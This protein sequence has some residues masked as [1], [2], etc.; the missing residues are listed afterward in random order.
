M[1]KSYSIAIVSILLVLLIGT[2][3]YIRSNPKQ[4]EE[5]ASSEPQIEIAK[6]DS[7]TVSQI[8]IESNENKLNIV[9]E[10]ES[11]ILNGN[12]D[13]TASQSTIDGIANTMS[14]IEAGSV[15]QDIES[16]SDYGLDNP[17]KLK[18][19]LND[20]KVYE[21]F[22]GNSTP[23]SGG[24]YF[25]MSE[26]EK[27]YIVSNRYKTPFEY[28]FEDLV[29]KEEIPSI[30]LENLNYIYI[31][32]VGNLEMEFVKPDEDKIDKYR[33]W[34]NI[35]T[36]EM[37]KPYKLVHAVGS[38]DIWSSVTSS[39]S[40]NSAVR[41]FVSNNP[42]DLSLYGLNKPKLEILVRDKDGVENH[43]YFG[44]QSGDGNVY[45][46]QANS[47]DVYTM[48]KSV[49]DVFMNLKPFDVVDKFNML[50]NIEDIQKIVINSDNKITQFDVTITKEK[51]EEDSERENTK[52]SCSVDGKE[53][54]E[55]D[56]KKFYQNIIGI[57]SDLE[58]S[59]ET[60]TGKPDLTISLHMSDG[61]IIESKYY[62]YNEKY[63]V[64]DRQG[65][66]EFLIDK[67]QIDNL[68]ERLNDF[69]NGTISQQ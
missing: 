23:T 26:D 6:F 47:K 50:I 17:K 29:Q 62:K 61:N 34:N 5:T 32:Q 22:M 56:F 30:L 13:I 67:R 1:K 52:I 38:N 42:D 45:F 41:N 25:K 65:I 20:G 40:F 28:K 59:G 69:L 57:T 3:F 64:F 54:P 33:T 16:L 66:Q 58:Y 21:F 51:S 46:K 18:L 10:N 27:I 35:A 44:N 12:R 60:F 68:F 53:Y 31:N 55:D 11:W 24:F 9:K 37:T 7:A 48:S 4:S 14:D 8:D 15:L 19:T 49:V 36:W 43:L 2:Y 63:Y 39:I